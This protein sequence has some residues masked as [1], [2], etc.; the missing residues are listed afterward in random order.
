[1]RISRRTQLAAAL[2]LGLALLV[3]GWRLTGP[4]RVQSVSSSQPALAVWKVK[5]PKAADVERLFAGGWDVL[6][7]RDG[8]YVLVLGDAATATQLRTAGFE[9]ELERTLPP[10]DANSVFT[11][12]G[13]YR[14][15]AEH[16]QHLD[17]LAA[18]Y[19]N[20]VTVVDY[21]DSWRKL[22]NLP[23]GH[24]LKAICITA[25][26]VGDCA[27]DPNSAKPRFVLQAAIHARELTTSELAWRWMD[28]LTSKY[29]IN[30]QITELLNYTELWVI[31]VVNPDGRYIVETGGNS[32]YTQRKNLHDYASGACSSPPSDFS[33]QG[34]DLNRNANFQWGGAGT[35]TSLCNLTYRGPSAASE[36]EEYFL[37]AFLAQLFPDSRPDDL[38][39]AAPLD[40]RGVFLTLHTYSDLSLLPWGWGTQDAPN[41]PGLRSLAFR[42]SYYNGYET[43]QPGE[44]LYNASGAT[45]DWVYGHLG[46]PGFTFEVGP[47]SGS[48]SGF[49]PA[50]SCQ[51]GTFWPLNKPAFLYAAS[52]ARQPY[53]WSLGPTPS[54]A[55]VDMV[56][57]D[58]GT[59]VTLTALAND[60]AYGNNGVARPSAQTIAA[61]EYSIDTPPWANGSAPYSMSA[62]DGT[63]SSTSEYLEATVD[64][65]ELTE[66][67]HTLWVRAQDS[68]GNWGPPAPVWLTIRSSQITPTPSPTATPVTTTPTPTPTGTVT[69]TLTPTPTGTVTATP[70]PTGSPTPTGTA[71]LTPTPGA[72]LDQRVYLPLVTR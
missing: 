32:P 25:K 27:L 53:A 9:I 62:A 42:F 38:T 58:A 37:E 43:G 8:A 2:L 57:V 26:Q 47:Q 33:Q 23:N 24:D 17:D 21:G 45:D 29:G 19:P 66:G 31:P 69:A 11:Y 64:T 54:N 52:V 18:T 61:A 20:L 70:T 14:T 22:N 68:A 10:V 35:S 65:S 49:F 1:M 7:A 63:F 72:V 41:E 6:E 3:G 56:S 34:V 15:V 4:A 50:Y 13:G 51:D 5:A 67:R 16:Y 39:T 30:T 40:T 59:P 60:D 71:T 46:V 48:C 12:Y 28:E 44:V 36:P 55:S